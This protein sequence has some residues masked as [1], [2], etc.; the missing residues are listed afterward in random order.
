MFHKKNIKTF[1]C[2]I[3]YS[4]TV[5][6]LQER[7]EALSTENALMK[8]D[9]NLSRDNTEK[10]QV[11]SHYIQIQNKVYNDAKCNR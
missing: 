2:L 6:S 10:T 11:N 1:W 9:L 7:V 5:G 3:Y 8:E 4:A